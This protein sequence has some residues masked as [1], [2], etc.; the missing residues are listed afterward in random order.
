MID[1]N[2]L[3]CSNYVPLDNV[4]FD[5]SWFRQN[6]VALNKLALNILNKEYNICYYYCR[7]E[8][9]ADLIYLMNTLVDANGKILIPNIYDDVEPLTKEEE[10][11]YK[12]IEFSVDEYKSDIG[13]NQ[14]LHDEDKVGTSIYYNIQLFHE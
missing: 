11:L 5:R 1:C 6:K 13:S 4:S 2:N 8:G 10:E 12:V 3:F 14:L 7:N 9:M